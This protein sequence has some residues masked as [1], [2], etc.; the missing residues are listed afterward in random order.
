MLLSR[1]LRVLPPLASAL[2]ES[3]TPILLLT[4][5]AS[6]LHSAL[7]LRLRAQGYATAWGSLGSFLASPDA[8]SAAE[9]LQASIVG[10]SLGCPPLLLT[11]GLGSYLAQKLLESY[12]LA[13]AVLLAPTSA[14]EPSRSLQR[15]A[16]LLETRGSGSSRGSSSGS[17]STQLQ[18]L[19]HSLQLCAGSAEQPEAQPSC[20]WAAELSPVL[21][22]PQP[23]P[24]LLLRSQLDAW[25]SAEDLAEAAAFHGLPAE[26]LAELPGSAEHSCGLHSA[27]AEQAAGLC[28]AVEAWLL[29]RF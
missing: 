1:S 5:S 15:W 23:V 4:A 12:P 27:D 21:L 22:E 8:D 18:L 25:C 20:S 16:A 13:G 26:Q 24:M 14:P 11:Q 7:A 9:A 19:Q 17:S 28:R 2:R 3:P 29:P 6:S 10:A